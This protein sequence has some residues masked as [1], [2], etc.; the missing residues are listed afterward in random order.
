MAA[1]SNSTWGTTE[2][3]Q[4]YATAQLTDATVVATLAKAYDGSIT[5]AAFRGAANHVAAT[6]DGA[7]T[8]GPASATVIPQGCNS[9]VWAAG[10]DWT[11]AKT[12]LP[13]PGQTIVHKFIDTRVHDS[14]WTQRVDAPTVTGTPVT[15]SDTGFT[16]DRW[17]MAA[18]EIPGT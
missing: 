5:V 15:V 14:F 11:H 9:L 3:W 4:T 17:T 1:R 13:A 12:P 8:G 2:V 16:T 18:V 6:A 7:G 10:H